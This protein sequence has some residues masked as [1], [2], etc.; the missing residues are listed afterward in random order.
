MNKKTMVIIISLILIISV[1]VAVGQETGYFLQ[2]FNSNANINSAITNS[3]VIENV[4][5]TN[6]TLN[7]NVNA[8]NISSVIING[9]NYT[10]QTSQS[11]GAPA[12][13]ITYYGADSLP[14]QLQTVSFT[15][16]TFTDPTTHQAIPSYHYYVW[17]TTIVNVNVVNSP[18]NIFDQLMEPLGTQFPA[19]LSEFSMW[20]GDSGASRVRGEFAGYN[21]NTAKSFLI[22]FTSQTLSEDEVANVTNALKT[23]VAPTL[24]DW[25]S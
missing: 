16:P 5:L 8:D 7:I 20:F 10:A 6:G 12:I 18:N 3:T 24:L 21:A 2:I 14:P 1:G 23:Q 11:S 15:L 9:V 4:T 25:Y 13:I 22:L 17:N 19:L